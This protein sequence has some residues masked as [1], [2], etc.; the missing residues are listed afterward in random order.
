M[1][2]EQAQPKE[3]G[4]EE[5]VIALLSQNAQ[6]SGFPF[7]PEPVVLK[8]DE[9][10]EVIAGLVGYTNWEW[11]YIE[12]L[13]VDESYRGKGLGRKLVEQAEQIARQRSCRGAWVDTFTF[14]S[15]AFYLRLG[16]EPF[17]KLE[18]YPQGQQRNFLR[19]Q[20]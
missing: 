5:A 7:E 4:V 3:D 6:A 16:Y 8:I 14:Q 13:A 17:G 1:H 9:K 12:M 20:L 10:G 2:V 19:K 11:L 15:P 18:D